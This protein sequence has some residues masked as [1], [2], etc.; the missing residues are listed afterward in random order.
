[1]GLSRGRAAAAP[2][3]LPVLPIP[4]QE[5]L[6]GQE[7]VPKGLFQG[8][9]G[10]P[11]RHLPLG[12][13]HGHREVEKVHQVPRQSHQEAHGNMCPWLGWRDRGTLSNRGDPTMRNASITGGQGGGGHH[14][15]HETDLCPRCAHHHTAQLGRTNRRITKSE[16]PIRR[17]ISGL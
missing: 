10:R 5:G 1:M 15:S 17:A 11:T 6:R 9:Q 2:G 7:G 3:A 16:A 13:Q 4:L 8:N 12:D 14:V